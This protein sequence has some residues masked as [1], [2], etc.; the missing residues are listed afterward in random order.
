MRCSANLSACSCNRAEPRPPAR[1]L[2]SPCCA[3]RRCAGSTA[4]SR[5]SFSGSGACF[6]CAHRRFRLRPFR[7]GIRD[8]RATREGPCSDGK[9]AELADVPR[10][11]MAFARRSRLSMTAAPTIACWRR[12]RSSP[13]TPGTA[14]LCSATLLNPFP[15]SRRRGRRVRGRRG[16]RSRI[17]RDV[18]GHPFHSVAWLATQLR[19]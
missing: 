17:G 4:R 14:A 13:T 6:R 9:H 2:D 12:S 8:R 1:R 16:H 7:P 11:S 10:P 15:T 5:A 18:L 3:C 19:R